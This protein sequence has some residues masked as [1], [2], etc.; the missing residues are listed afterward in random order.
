M[1]SSIASK[2]FGL[3]RLSY[4][5][6]AATTVR[7]EFCLATGQ[8]QVFVG[9]RLVSSQIGWR[10]RTVHHFEITGQPYRVVCQTLSFW[11]MQVSLE[12]WQAE[13]LLDQ[14]RLDF[15]RGPDQQQSWWYWL[16]IKVLAAVGAGVA[17]GMQLA[18]WWFS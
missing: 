8:Q 1:T 17:V 12:L 16:A 18:I 4:F 7:V 2:D 10:R 5:D 6:V 15:R 3:T 9:H 13:C 14:D 11:R